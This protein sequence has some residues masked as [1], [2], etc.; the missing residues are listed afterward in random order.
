MA[1]D[2]KAV[3]DWDLINTFIRP[4]F[5]FNLS[6]KTYYEESSRNLKGFNATNSR[7]KYSFL[8]ELHQQEDVTKK[9][10]GVLG[11]LKFPK[12]GGGSKGEDIMPRMGWDGL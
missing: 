6:E 4:V 7:S 8:Q 3:G 1:A 2:A 12:L 11:G 9:S 5:R 10:G